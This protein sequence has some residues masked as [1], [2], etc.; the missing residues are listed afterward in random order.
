MRLVSCLTLCLLF[1]V[2]LTP[3]AHASTTTVAL[4]ST[5]HNVSNGT[6]PSPAVHHSHP[7]PHGDDHDSNDGHGSAISHDNIIV[8]LMYPLVILTVGALVEH[9]LFNSPIP[10]TVII[11][12]I[13][14]LIGIIQ[15]STEGSLEETLCS[16]H[17]KTACIFGDLSISADLV[18]EI[19]PHFLLNVF[20]PILI[21][22]SAFSTDWH[23][24]KNVMGKASLLAG[25]GLVIASGLTA[26]WVIYCRYNTAAIGTDWVTTDRKWAM[27]LLFGAIT[28][29]TDPVAVV[30]VLKTIGAPK[31][32][33]VTIEG[34]S[35]LNDGV[36]VVAFYVL[37][38]SVRFGTETNAADVSV[39]FFVMAG[40]GML[41]GLLMG[42]VV[43]SWISLA[44]DQP[45][46]EITATVMA[47]Y[48]TFFIGEEYLHVS[49]VLAVVALGIYFSAVGHFSITPAVL[50]QLHGLW[51]WL[52]FLANTLVFGITGVL[53]TRPTIQM[54]QLQNPSNVGWLLFNCMAL[55]LALMVIR[56]LVFLLFYPVLHYCGREGYKMDWK[57]CFVSTW[58][59]LRGA[60]GLA[61]AMVVSLDARHREVD[62]APCVATLDNQTGLYAVS[63]NDDDGICGGILANNTDDTIAYKKFSE[64][65]LIGVVS[66]V[67][68]TLLFNSTT[69]KSLMACM[70]MND[71]SEVQVRLFEMAME[72]IDDAAV[73]EIKVLREDASLQ[74]VDWNQV[75]DSRY[76][77]SRRNDLSM[78]KK[79]LTRL[80]AKRRAALMKTKE[81]KLE[82]RRRFLS[83]C[84]SSYHKQNEHAVLS[85]RSLRILTEA[86]NTAVDRECD[87]HVEWLYIIKSV[88]FLGLADYMLTVEH[89]DLF[90]ATCGVMCKLLV[91]RQWHILLLL[92]HLRT[93]KNR[94]M[95]WIIGR[96]VVSSIGRAC[97]TASAFLNARE[98]AIDLLKHYLE[99]EANYSNFFD[100]AEADMATAARAVMCCHRFFPDIVRSAETN[101]ATRII[102]YLQKRR[103][104]ELI[105]EGVLDQV[106]GNRV[107]KSLD[108]RITNVMLSQRLCPKLTANSK[109]MLLH[110]IA[111]LQG[112]SPEL[113][114]QV[115]AAAITREYQIDE[116]IVDYNTQP[117]YIYVICH[118]SVAI[119]M[120]VS[121]QA[122]QSSIQALDAQLLQK[123]ED[124]TPAKSKKAERPAPKR[125][126]P[127]F[128]RKSVAIH[129]ESSHDTKGS[130]SKNNLNL[131][132]R[133][134]SRANKIATSGS[135][136]D[137]FLGQMQLPVTHLNTGSSI[138]ELS[139]MDNGGKTK[140][141]AVASST[142][143]E[144]IGI[145]LALVKKN[146]IIQ[147]NLTKATGRKVVET[148]LSK[149]IRFR[150]W[151]KQQLVREVAKWKIKETEKLYASDQYIAMSF[152][153]PVV[154]IKGAAFKLKHR[155]RT[156]EAA[157]KNV[158]QSL[159][160]FQIVITEAEMKE[161]MRR[162][163]V[164]CRMEGPRYLRP[165]VSD[166][167]I[168]DS[169][170]TTVTWYVRSESMLCF[171]D[172][173]RFHYITGASEAIQSE[174]VYSNMRNVF[175]M[176]ALGHPELNNED[177]SHMQAVSVQSA[178]TSAQNAMSTRTV[179][180]LGRLR[181]R[182]PS[183][184]LVRMAVEQAHPDEA[185]VEL[186]ERSK[187]P[188]PVVESKIVPLNAQTTTNDEKNSKATGSGT[189]K[190]RRRRVKP[191]TKS[192]SANTG[193]DTAAPPNHTTGNASEGETVSTNPQPMFQHVPVGTHMAAQLH[194]PG[195]GV[196]VTGTR[197]VTAAELNETKTG[198][199][200]LR[201]FES[202]VE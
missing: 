4:N 179:K 110:E 107:V 66:V 114:K 131:L 193:Q 15:D 60:V 58:G 125:R 174:R 101:R 73:E 24:F 106:L 185:E 171:N 172:H 74:G 111:W 76:E 59:A 35:L 141:C 126:A 170:D 95:N 135:S 14:A 2:S 63:S 33:A 163:N 65:L 89:K 160:D 55:N 10:Y 86:I 161:A 3:N 183:W 145:P 194:P 178:M 155:C 176:F 51:E 92:L 166:D 93:R 201:N 182:A 44:Y 177:T 162:G 87:L 88:P 187:E 117:D 43:T 188:E 102:L 79:L 154:L 109:H 112:L 38:D 142:T 103:T 45:M 83:A 61:L 49:G 184:G 90:K 159:M 197:V 199:N 127:S 50:E 48:L 78:S 22:E 151:T 167:R 115:E 46:V 36:A 99:Q 21:F 19:D 128:R 34:E 77:V 28:S 68:F 132:A 98:E 148:V 42:L 113:M 29:A 150:T 25:P 7:A 165:H 138:G 53:I 157:H 156:G 57:D 6:S 190:P 23:V 91:Q 11:F 175:R 195:S 72:K 143:V 118:G 122:V 18:A 8:S 120:D 39:T 96:F 82:A 85:G 1:V 152:V 116:A 119:H 30:S 41:W 164:L 26:C 75:S 180:L 168:D 153:M 121:A 133:R 67:V 129:P 84:M 5:S 146:N 27:G 108:Q 104:T 189:G 70:K 20:L 71:L 31:Y 173:C 181:N 9:L 37:F 40:L 100:T 12:L 169:L 80:R 147:S 137:L 158:N 200:R 186:V 13:G 198:R 32:L 54:L 202:L 17:N 124:E 192:G 69:I 191:G 140:F 105:E 139:W 149:Q 123:P 47:A 136:R 62:A 56:A 81:A 144:V 130:R 64:H 16:E 196:T 134:M 97:D 94:C 52:G